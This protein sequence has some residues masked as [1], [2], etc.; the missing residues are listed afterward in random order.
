MLEESGEKKAAKDAVTMI[1]LFCLTVKTE[2]TGV[3]CGCDSL[4]GSAA[5]SDCPSFRID[6][7]PIGWVSSF[8]TGANGRLLTEVCLGVL[9]DSGERICFSGAG[10]A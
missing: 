10:C 6:S 9:V 1:N 4:G 3:A 7:K 5:G 2:C 8:D